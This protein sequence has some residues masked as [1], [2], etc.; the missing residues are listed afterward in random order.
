MS[1]A[2]NRISDA[3]AQLLRSAFESLK[4]QLEFPD[5]YAAFA[6]GSIPEGFGNAASDIDITIVPNDG[7]VPPMSTLV[8]MHDTL[9]G[10]RPIDITFET[11][12]TLLGL[13]ATIAGVSRD[14]PQ[15]AA[16]EALLRAHRIRYAFAL[17]NE[18][19]VD[20]IR[21]AFD[22]RNLSA[23]CAQEAARAA[24]DAVTRS[25]IYALLGQESRAQW[26]ART[27]VEWAAQ[28][29][30]ARRGETY[31]GKWLFERLLRAGMPNDLFTKVTAIVAGQGAPSPEFLRDCQ[32][33]LVLLE[34]AD[35]SVTSA[36]VVVS[37]APD[38]HGFEIGGTVYLTNGN[39]EILM[40][41]EAASSVWKCLGPRALI[42]DV[43]VEGA[44]D[45][46][47]RQRALLELHAKRLI[48]L[49]HSESTYRWESTEPID[50]LGSD[51][52]ERPIITVMGAKFQTSCPYA[53]R[54]LPMTAKAF[55]GAGMAMIT[56]LILMQNTRDDAIGAFEA[57]QWGAFSTAVRRIARDICAVHLLSRGIHPVADRADIFSIGRETG[58]IPGQLLTEA[59]ALD[60]VMVRNR[61]EAS[62]VARE[63]E[64]MIDAIPEA[65][66]APP[67]RDCYRTATA[68]MQSLDLA[69]PWLQLGERAGLRHSVAYA[70]K[71]AQSVSDLTAS[72]TSDAL[73][74]AA[75]ATDAGVR[76]KPKLVEAAF[77]AKRDLRFRLDGNAG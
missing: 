23:L 24:T 16:R 31:L 36:N 10:P 77:S 14:Q 21:S 66:T 32:Q 2:G 7:K 35:V 40:L 13:A 59:E 73:S 39:N 47:S 42:R 26:E 75:A 63:L 49:E 12:D 53:I 1:I 37:P 22:E 17:Q 38:I 68:Y 70:R 76:I 29:W 56:R 19:A 57:E 51:Q 62:S 18:A 25:R 27:A 60:R 58:A 71:L 3:S 11:K 67:I 52:V 6:E 20:E 34:A 65:L 15:A 55:A 44:I 69:L 43:L 41:T 74:I 72:S 48:V 33:A 50:Q 45:A 8:A 54:T 46:G 28:A 64:R 4:T 61:A 5:G 30:A 9:D